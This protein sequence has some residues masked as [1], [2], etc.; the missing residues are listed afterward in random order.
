MKSKKLTL[1]RHWPIIILIGIATFFLGRISPQSTP[2]SHDPSQ[3]PQKSSHRLDSASD[4]N[5]SKSGNSL[6]SSRYRLPVSAA[7]TSNASESE[8]LLAQLLK[9][10]EDDPLGA[11]LFA[12][13]EIKPYV[14]SQKLM[15]AL[16]QQWATSEP[17]LAWEWAEDNTPNQLINLLATIA[18]VDAPLG[19]EKAH[20][21]AALNPD[22]LYRSYV[23]VIE[24]TI[25]NGDHELALD[26]LLE[27]DI[28]QQLSAR[29]GKYSFLEDIFFDWA[30]YAPEDAAA[31]I[32]AN[33]E[34]DDSAL[35]SLA[36]Q[37]LLKA[38][39]YIDPVA[40][41]DYALTLSQDTPKRYAVDAS[42][43]HLTSLDFAQ[44]ND[45]L[46]TH[47]DN[48][49]WY[50]PI[51][52][53]FSSKVQLSDPQMSPDTVE[54]AIT[55]AKQIVDGYVQSD[56]LVH[57]ASDLIMHDPETARSRLGEVSF[58]DDPSFND[59]VWEQAEI[60]AADRNADTYPSA[61]EAMIAEQQ[62]NS[63]SNNNF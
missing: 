8:E 63:S 51:I 2:S 44:A 21:A 47:A 32:A 16:L 46:E 3:T 11:L 26:L 28:P 35:K 6:K 1:S 48:S 13:N 22:D 19:W 33:P 55:W 31:W 5:K 36:N 20:I 57:I 45:W 40:T 17:E 23:N 50:D 39:T 41:M 43:E 7:R 59:F 9:W 25:H 62:P 52:H 27:A 18:E 60:R 12:Q 53:D 61:Y 10:A 15:L 58:S 38:W 24:G 14:E 56:A 29:D 4:S 30:K 42:F 37:S 49:G 54:R 34:A